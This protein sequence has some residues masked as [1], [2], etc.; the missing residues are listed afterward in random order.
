VIR[1]ETFPDSAITEGNAPFPAVRRA[2]LS[3]L[4]STLNYPGVPLTLQF[5]WE[6]KD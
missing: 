1:K 3:K 5:S 6:V 2:K 4:L